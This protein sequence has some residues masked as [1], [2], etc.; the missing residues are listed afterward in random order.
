[1]PH[2][3]SDLLFTL[4]LYT[5]KCTPHTVL[6]SMSANSLCCIV[7]SSNKLLS[8]RLSGNSK[9]LG[10]SL[11]VGSEGGVRNIALSL[12]WRRS[13]LLAREEFIV[14]CDCAEREPERCTAG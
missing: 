3:C 6:V 5:Q 7:T 10:S 4:G 13:C 2:L 9:V 14:R 12:R 8:E 1:M 11:M